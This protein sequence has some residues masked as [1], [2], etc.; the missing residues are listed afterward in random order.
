M[1]IRHRNWKKVF[2]LA[3]LTATMGFVSGSVISAIGSWRRCDCLA[4]DLA[5]PIL[6]SAISVGFYLLMII[7]ALMKK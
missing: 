4:V 1:L 5:F 3:V 2:L 7:I 6:V